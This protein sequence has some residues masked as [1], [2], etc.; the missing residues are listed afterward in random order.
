M[1]KFS[2]WPPGARTA[3]GTALCRW[4][5]L[6]RYFVSESSEFFRQ[7]LC[8]ASQFIIIVVVVVVIIIIIIIIIIISLLLSS[9]TFGYTP[10]QPEIEASPSPQ[11]RLI[12]RGALPTHLR[13][14]ILHRNNFTFTEKHV[15]RGTLVYFG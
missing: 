4:V 15:R 12:I 5:Q 8:A 2:D 13:L 11:S 7:T 9:E 14:M 6:Y 1:Q 3:N 10:Y